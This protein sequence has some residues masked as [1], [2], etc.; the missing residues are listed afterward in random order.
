MPDTRRDHARA[1]LRK[2]DPILAH[3]IDAHRGFNPR[4]WLT[5][6]PPMDAFGALVFQVIGQQLS[7]RATR[8]MLDR[9]LELFDGA[10]PTPAALLAIA[11]EELMK[12]GLSRRKV[13]TLREVA[14]RFTDGR[15]HDDEL[16]RLSD[17][18]VE[19]RAPHDRLRDRPV[20]GP[21]RVDHRLRSAG[22][23]PAGRPCPSQGGSTRLRDGPPAHS[24]RSSCPGGAV[25]P[26]AEPGDRIS[27]PGCVRGSE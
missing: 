14:E 24:G 26:M 6:L 15:W 5:D 27:F 2:V 23:H 1:G 9:L 13:A 7:V 19:E 4:A 12:V 17:R 21:R 11:S 18:E 10:L 20:D 22:R 16:R 3:L 25:A 8:R